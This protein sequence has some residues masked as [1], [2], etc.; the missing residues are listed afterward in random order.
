MDLSL[1]NLSFGLLGGGGGDFLT[2]DFGA[3][4]LKIAKGTYKNGQDSSINLTLAD[5]EPIGNPPPNE[6][7]EELTNSLTTLLQRN[8]IGENQRVILALPTNVVIVRYLEL[9]EM[10]EDRMNQVIRYEAESHIPFPL[11]EVVLDFHV[12]KRT[13]EATEV[14]L[15]AVKEEKLNEY[16]QIA[17]GAGL[18]PEIIDISAFSLFNLYRKMGLIQPE[19]DQVSGSNQNQ[20]SPPDSEKITDNSDQSKQDQPSSASESRTRALVDI[21]HENTDIIIFKGGTLHF[22]RSASVAGQSINEQIANRLDVEIDEA[23]RLKHQFSYVPLDGIDSAEQGGASAEL[24]GSQA[25]QELAQERQKSAGPSEDSTEDTQ[26]GAE[27]TDSPDTSQ[28]PG[29]E[30][31]T[32]TESDSV[33][34]AATGD[35]DLGRP[36]K[37]SGSDTI[38]EGDEQASDTTDSVKELDD[39]DEDLN[40]SLDSSNQRLGTSKDPSEQTESED[41]S[42]DPGLGLGVPRKPAADDR[43]EK[44]SD[45]SPDEPSPP[46][47]PGEEDRSDDI[48]EQTGDESMEPPPPP[49]PEEKSVSSDSASKP[50]NQEEENHEA[51]QEKDFDLG[52]SLQSSPGDEGDEEDDDDEDEGDSLS[53]G[54]AE[55]SDPEPASDQETRREV[56]KA[57][58]SQIDRLIGELRHTFDYFQSQLGG[59][60]VDEIILVGGGSNLKNLAAYF[61]DQLDLPCSQFHPND[62]V[63][64][65]S[66]DELQTYLVPGG[67]VLRAEEKRS[68][69][70]IN[71]LPEDVIQR[72]RSQTRQKKLTAMGT[73]GGILFLQLLGAGYLMYDMQ[74]REK[75]M[76]E[77]EFQ[78]LQPIVQQVE[79]LQNR[80]RELE[81]RIQII[82]RLKNEQTDMLALLHAL[83]KLPEGLREKTWFETLNYQSDSAKGGIGRL[84]LTGMTEDFD[85]ASRIYRWMQDLDLVT[86]I[87][88]ESQTKKEYK[89]NGKQRSFASFSARAIVK[90]DQQSTEDD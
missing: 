77:K 20:T 85:D 55:N 43:E 6:R 48:E 27:T 22:A 49:P 79:Q 35:L 80:N 89:I 73:L 34:S 41:Q 58:K 53:L 25:L 45:A 78:Q 61:E 23:E 81:Q 2:L 57:I 86:E 66:N 12:V 54:A 65:I 88:D 50:D 8:G 71:L 75:Q 42:N 84:Q 74:F 56:G 90:F 28:P 40:L 19:N 69:I 68:D 60:A 83:N 16:V 62:A 21:G 76:A 82:T 51:D 47:A 33:D 29:E 72:R 13:E 87:A 18:N 26:S 7:I 11:E 24:S 3:S 4:S 9:P 36:S 59:G 14:I 30:N 52:S 10:P 15:I 5:R 32:V 39:T 44:T 31:D 46:T 17:H 37:P 63:H 64:G 1:D 70:E 67:L 38:K